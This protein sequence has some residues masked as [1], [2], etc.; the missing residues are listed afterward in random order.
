MIVLHDINWKDTKIW[1][2]RYFFFLYTVACTYPD[3]P[4]ATTK[5]KYYDFIQNLPLFIPD[6]T[7]ANHFCHLLDKYPVSPYLGSR[8]SFLRWVS[9]I[10]NKINILL[11]K[12]EISLLESI[13]LYKNEYKPRPIYLYETVRMRRQ[14]FHLIL[15][16]LLFLLLYLFYDK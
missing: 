12:E 3:Y 14:I 1:L 15:I 5:R 2:P 6:E 8:D 9:F 10:Q 7:L 13:D 16:L 11:G 4:N